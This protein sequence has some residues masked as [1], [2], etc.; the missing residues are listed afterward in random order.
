MIISTSMSDRSPDIPELPDR[1]SLSATPAVSAKQHILRKS[2]ISF[3]GTIGRPLRYLQSSAQLKREE[4]DLFELPARG[5][6]LQGVAAS[7]T[8]YREELGAITST[9][10]SLS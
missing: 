9:V 1:R 10:W 8:E 3:E 6:E 4:C 7:S 5:P 2:A